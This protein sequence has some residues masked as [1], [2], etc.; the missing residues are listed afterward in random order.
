MIRGELCVLKMKVWITCVHRWQSNHRFQFILWVLSC[1]ARQC[2]LGRWCYLESATKKLWHSHDRS[3]QKNIET[4]TKKPHWWCWQ[5][6]CQPK[7]LIDNAEK[8]SVITITACKAPSEGFFKWGVQATHH[9]FCKSLSQFKKC[10]P[11]VN[12]CH[13]MHSQAVLLPGIYLS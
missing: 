3:L 11:D 13:A 10:R 7:N 6:I 2:I 12:S 9:P 1:I 5:E 4:S 8:K